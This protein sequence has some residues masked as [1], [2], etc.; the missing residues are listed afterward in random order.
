MAQCDRLHRRTP[1][2][3]GGPLDRLLACIRDA[4]AAVGTRSGVSGTGAAA[5]TTGAA[6]SGRGTLRRALII[7]PCIVFAS[8]SRER[9][10]HHLLLVAAVAAVVVVAGG[11]GTAARTG[12]VRAGAK[13]ARRADGSR[14]PSGRHR[15]SGAATCGAVLF[16]GTRQALPPDGG[17]VD[18]AGH[19]RIA[20]ASHRCP[21]AIGPHHR[22]HPHRVAP[23]RRRDRCVQHPPLGQQRQRAVRQPAGGAGGRFPAGTRFGGAGAAARLR[24]GGD[25]VQCDRAPGTRRGAASGQALARDRSARCGRFIGGEQRRIRTALPAYRTVHAQDVVQDRLA[26]VQLVSRGHPAECGYAALRGAGAGG[27]AVRRPP[28]AGVSAGGR[29][30]GLCRAGGTHGQAGNGRFT[31]GH[32][33]RPGS[34]GDG[35]ALRDILGG[36]AAGRAIRRHRRRVRVRAAGPWCGKDPGAGHRARRRRRH[37]SHRRRYGRRATGDTAQRR[38]TCAGR[39]D[40]T[41]APPSEVNE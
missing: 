20:G 3:L 19:G 9:P 35:R 34:V 21:D 37:R 16:R 11:T 29:R 12:S 17:V 40:A 1:L 10:A 27:G 7:R 25:S 33:H 28:R 32:H 5:T 8:A 41:G 38:P 2:P 36:H 24:C 22:A 15:P 4:D 6:T 13:T 31:R 18:G 14:A 26:P 39:P 23:A 30:D